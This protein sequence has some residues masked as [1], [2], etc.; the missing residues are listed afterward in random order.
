MYTLA[1]ASQSEVMYPSKP[2]ASRATLLSSQLFA[3]EGMPLTSSGLGLGLVLGLV[4]GLGVG[5][6][7]ELGLG[8]GLTSLYEHMRPETLPFSTHACAEGGG[9]AGG[10]GPK[11]S[12]RGGCL[13]VMGRRA[14]RVAW[15]GSKKESRRRGEQV[16]GAV[17]GH[18]A[19]AGCRGRVQ[20]QG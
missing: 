19:G 4:L 6:G 2:Q 13:Q 18:G 12:P 7:L 20:G 9:R 5:L 3:H 17:Q 15:K 10:R 16:R 14:V 11:G 1:S 8:L